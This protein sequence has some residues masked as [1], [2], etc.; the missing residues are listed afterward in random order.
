MATPASPSLDKLISW[1]LWYILSVENSSVHAKYPEAVQ[2]HWGS[3][4]IKGM[5]KDTRNEGRRC[6]L[7]DCSVS[8]TW[9]NIPVHNSLQQHRNF[10]LRS[11]GSGLGNGLAMSLW[12]RYSQGC[13][14]EGLSAAEGS[15]SELTYTTVFHHM[16]GS[17]GRQSVC[18]HSCFPPSEN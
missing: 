4:R 7:G 10:S 18:F 2:G 12:F 5:G 8:A 11:L 1:A 3:W 9:P 6:F 14:L 13:A 15:V 16:G 17:P